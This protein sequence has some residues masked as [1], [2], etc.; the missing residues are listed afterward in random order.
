MTTQARREANFLGQSSP[1]PV[2]EQEHH[3]LR[4]LLIEPAARFPRDEAALVTFVPDASLLLVP[5]AALSDG[6]GTHLTKAAR[7]RPEDWAAFVLL[8]EP[9]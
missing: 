9:R 3:F 8:G 7:T 1:A 4:H 2:D 5:F 6:A